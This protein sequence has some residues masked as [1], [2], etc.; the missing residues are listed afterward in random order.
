MDTLQVDNTNHY[1]EAINT[2]LPMLII[3]GV[4]MVVL[5]VAFLPYWLTKKTMP[6]EL[7]FGGGLVFAVT[8][9][10]VILAFTM[11]ASLTGSS[12]AADITKK[13]IVEALNSTYDVNLTPTDIEKIS[14]SGLDPEEDS[15]RIYDLKTDPTE[16]ESIIEIGKG[17][18]VASGV[19]T[20]VQVWVVDNK[21]KMFKDDGKSP[22]QDLVELPRK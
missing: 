2:W 14:L 11:N 17:R 13:N 8:T 5:L 18:V 9:L 15:G 7:G 3:C 22:L 19:P 21:L 4:I 16:R 12:I 1:W 6:E 10:V 20:E